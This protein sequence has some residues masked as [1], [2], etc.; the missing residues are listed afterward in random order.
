MAAVVTFSPESKTATNENEEQDT[1]ATTMTTTTKLVKDT[2]PLEQDWVPLVQ[3]DARESFAY[4][5]PF[6]TH[7][8]HS[9]TTYT[10]LDNWFDALHPNQYVSSTHSTVDKRAWTAAAYHGQPL[11]RQTA[12]V[13]LNDEC[14]CE[15]GYS[16]TWQERSTCPIFAR[17]IREIAAH[18]QDAMG[19]QFN[20][21]NLN[22]YPTGAGLGWHAD[23]EF[24][25]NAYHEPVTIVSLSL[26]RGADDGILAG[27][28]KF[29]IRPKHHAPAPGHHGGVTELVLKHGDLMTMEGYFQKHYLH[30]V[31]PGDSM[32]Y[33]DDP[34][35]QGERINLTFRTIVQHLDGSPASRGKACPLA[36]PAT[37]TTSSSDNKSKN[38]A[39]SE[40]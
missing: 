5:L 18:V 26:C 29:M 31:W 14:T 35:V 6:D 19:C 38:K 2:S 34:Y 8:A 11:L 15:Y 1:A 10:Q 20:A 13:T 9:W 27:A 32:Y 40:E 16:D 30:S 24:L 37:T 3:D 23:D 4:V 17:T 25:W 12:W 22:Y 28:R 39:A 36:T 7:H 21:C 33:Q